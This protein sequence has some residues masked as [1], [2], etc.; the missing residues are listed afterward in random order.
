[1]GTCLCDA[2]YPNVALASMDC[3][4]Y[5]GFNVI[6][7]EDQT[8]CS[9]PA[10][11]SGD[12]KSARAVA[13]HI[14]KVFKDAETLIVPSGSC[15]A[16]IRWGYPQLFEGEDDYQ[17]ALALAEKTWE[18]TEFLDQVANLA[19]WEGKLEKTVALHRSCHMRELNAGNAPLKLLSGIEGLVVKEI[20]FHEQCCGFGGTFA[21]TFPWT[22]NEMGTNK[23]QQ[24]K[25]SGAEEIVS[26]DMGCVMH[27]AGLQ[28]SRDEMPKFPIRHLV[29]ILRESLEPIVEQA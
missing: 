20:P 29:E 2:F 22:S 12:W 23:L 4:E 26:T 8:C 28:N 14:L 1:M 16:M 3:L 25:E 21:A 27:L 11:N 13:R 10:F 18:I 7:D 19:P 17:E 9:Q 15:A 24:M 5:A 6:F